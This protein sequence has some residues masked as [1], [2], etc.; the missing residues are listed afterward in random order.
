VALPLLDPLSLRTESAPMSPPLSLQNSTFFASQPI[1]TT[2]TME[3][4]QNLSEIQDSSMSLMQQQLGDI[5]SP[6]GQELTPTSI[7]TMD[8]V[9]LSEDLTPL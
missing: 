9:T 3:S 6:M 5:S 4:C 7:T 8:G 1:N 2:C